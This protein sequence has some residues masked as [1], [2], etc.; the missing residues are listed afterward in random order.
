MVLYSEFTYG[1]QFSE[2][3]KSLNKYKRP[4]RFNLLR[5]DRMTLISLLLTIQLPWLACIRGDMPLKR[6][7]LVEAARFLDSE[8]SKHEADVARIVITAREAVKTATKADNNLAVSYGMA[9]LAASMFYVESA[10]YG[11]N[12]TSYTYYDWAT[13]VSNIGYF[14]GYGAPHLV[15][16]QL[17][18]PD[19]GCGMAQVAAAWRSSSVPQLSEIYGRLGE[20]HLL[21]PEYQPAMVRQVVLV[22]DRLVRQV[23]SC[24]DSQADVVTVLDKV[25]SAYLARLEVTQMIIDSF[26]V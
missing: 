2:E 12:I 11:K 24:L 18:S 4:C 14:W 1:Y 16:G 17:G 23:V 3:T 9:V 7:V 25:K 20:D 21:L 8:I 15:D 10:V 26:S 13:V 22:R 5:L 19:P 6:A